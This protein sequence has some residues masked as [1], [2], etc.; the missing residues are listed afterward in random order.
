MRKDP[1]QEIDEPFCLRG[2]PTAECQ[3]TVSFHENAGYNVWVLN[4]VAVATMSA[5]VK[6]EPEI[7]EKACHAGP[8][9]AASRPRNAVEGVSQEIAGYLVRSMCL[10]TTGTERRL[11]DDVHYGEARTRD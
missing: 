8:L 9:S 2:Q 6:L 1:T 10:F 7:D 5:M 4:V 3:F 11:Q